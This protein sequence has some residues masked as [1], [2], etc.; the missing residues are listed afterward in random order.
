MVVKGWGLG[1]GGRGWGIKKREKARSW[2]L[3][4]ASLWTLAHLGSPSA[5]SKRLTVER[6]Q[7]FAA[8]RAVG[9][10]WSPESAAKDC[11]NQVCQKG[12]AAVF[13]F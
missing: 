8:C 3:T 7:M 1:A 6:A 10:I 4:L 12:S 11:S 13:L 9:I 2:R 5:K